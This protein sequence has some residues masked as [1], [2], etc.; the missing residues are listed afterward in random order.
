MDSSNFS[1]ILAYMQSQ[2]ML[3]N[4]V[5]IHL[6][7]R[8]LDSML[9]IGTA[10]FHYRAN[11]LLARVHLFT[12]V[13]ENKPE[14]TNGWNAVIPSERLQLVPVPA[15]HYTIMTEP[16]LQALGYAITTALTVAS[17]PNEVWDPS[18]DSENENANNS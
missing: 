14:I 4:D 10:L 17:T 12:A 18:S 11:E 5:D 13:E 3:D 9:A 1:A 15:N 16:H 7:Q 2:K 6:I 8:M